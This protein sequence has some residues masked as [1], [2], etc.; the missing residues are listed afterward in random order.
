MKM[1]LANMR[2]AFVE[3]RFLKGY[4]M[5]AKLL[6]LSLKRFRILCEREIKPIITNLKESK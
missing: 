5:K 3:N 1:S 4:R 2:L 6:A